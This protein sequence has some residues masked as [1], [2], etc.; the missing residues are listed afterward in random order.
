MPR[1]LEVHLVMDDYATHKTEAIQRW[2]LRHPRYHVHFTPTTSSWL[3]L[4]ESLFAIVE[5]NVTR[6]GVHRSVAA[7]EKAVRAFLEA[8]NSDPEPFLWTK[9]ADQ[10][11]DKLERYCSDANRV[12]QERL[13]RLLK[14]SSAAP[15]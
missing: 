15:C 13:N 6:R 8:H 5:R 3:D 14:R 4:V 1:D 9:T 7:L 11:L 10:I 12:R 2:L